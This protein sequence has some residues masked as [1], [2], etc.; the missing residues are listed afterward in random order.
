MIG[1]LNGG[2]VTGKIRDSLIGF[3]CIDF[4]V[5]IPTSGDQE[6]CLPPGAGGHLSRADV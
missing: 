5:P 6:A 4:S 2:K 3:V 1:V